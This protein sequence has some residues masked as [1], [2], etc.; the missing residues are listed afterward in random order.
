MCML[1]RD[2]QS[3]CVIHDTL[4]D[5]NYYNYL[6]KF[7]SIHVFVLGNKCFNRLEFEHIFFSVN[8][9]VL[10]PLFRSW[11]FLLSFIMKMKA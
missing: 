2:M 1:S 6:V 10:E 8:L 7:I 9:F 3:R 4:S 5:Y 11:S